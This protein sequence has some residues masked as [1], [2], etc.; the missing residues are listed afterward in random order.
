MKLKVAQTWF[1]AL[2]AEVDALL[3]VDDQYTLLRYSDTIGALGG[4]AENYRPNAPL[5]NAFPELTE[6]LNE[7]QQF[8][9]T[10]EI[11]AT[12]ENQLHADLKIRCSKL[13]SEG[14][15]Q[16]CLAIHQLKESDFLKSQLT[17]LKAEFDSVFTQ[18]IDA[19]IFIDQ[20]GIIQKVNIATTTLF[21]YPADDLLGN[22][23]SILMPT[24][25]REQHDH[26]ISNYLKSGEAKIIGIGRTVYGQRKDGSTFPMRLAVNE[27]R[28]NNESFFTGIIQNLSREKAAAEKIKKLNAA[29]E[30]RI[31]QRTAELSNTVSKLLATNKK[32]EQVLFQKENITKALQQSE[33]ELKESLRKEKS[34][35]DL[36]SRFVTT[37][38]H[39]FRTPLS[40]IFSSAEIIQLLLDKNQPNKINKHL[41]RITKSVDSLT[42]I[43]EEFLSL[44]KLEEGRQVAT[45]KSND[46]LTIL[47]ES[48][49]HF[50][51][52]LKDQQKIKL[53]TNAASYELLTDHQILRQIFVNLFSDASKYS[54]EKSIISCKLLVEKE[55]YKVA[56]SDR[57]IGIPEGDMPHLFSRFFRAKNAI[58][59]QGTGLGLNITSRF[60]KLINGHISAESILGEGSTFTISLPKN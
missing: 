1:E 39:E 14:H 4:S 30:E 13:S 19:I 40:S 47:K 59:I 15:P 56:I 46:L 17:T 8:P 23:I 58:N 57:G 60:I 50:S 24:P 22:N 28:I 55:H 31:E 52:S 48:I 44:S 16:Y 2:A 51:P 20:K 27:I 32:M 11:S 12:S 10:V 21:D 45:F 41:D 5:A 3:L 35:G 9:A 38:S 33:A 6:A 25:H 36:K 29:L 26:Y 37:A 43:L 53:K 18:A 54:P 34:L 7:L 42:A 49:D